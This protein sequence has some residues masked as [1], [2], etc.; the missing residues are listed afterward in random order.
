MPPTVRFVTFR[1]RLGEGQALADHLLHAASLVADAPGCE[2]WLVSRDHAEPDTVRVTERWASG[3]QCDAA[4]R[5]EGVSENA[6]RVMA[7]L[8]SAP[9]I[10]DAEPL[11]G[12]RELRGTTGATA[13]SILDAPDLS[14]DTELLDAYGLQ[15]V[16][17]ARYVREELGGVQTGLTHYRLLPG[18]R[19]GWAHR[20]GT[21]E[22]TYVAISGSGRVKVDDELLELRPLGAVRVAPGSIRELEAGP[23][24]LEVL[25]FGSHTPGDGEMVADWWTT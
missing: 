8:R 7:L 4:L 20:H 23:E 3:E 16:G 19:L 1:A 9:E 10:A 11:G 14:M 6:E 12:A 15:S 5:L 18:R 24:G 25:A 13:F 2:L 21:A 22:E 17:E